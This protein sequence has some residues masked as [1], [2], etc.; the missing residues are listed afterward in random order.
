MLLVRHDSLL[1]A[2]VGCAG[3]RGQDRPAHPADL[4]ESSWSP[5][6]RRIAFDSNRAGGPA[7]LYV[8]DA[9]GAN[10][11]NLTNHG[12]FD[13]WPAWSPDGRRIVFGSNRSG[14]FRIWV[15]NADGSEAQLLADVPGRCTSPKWSPD[16]RWI[17]FD[18]ALE[19]SCEI[20]RVPAPT[21]QGL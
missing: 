8:M 3:A 2:A 1:A 5:D 17:S 6:S 15:M 4:R 16:G 19:R 10:A 11:R 12:G 13:G 20:L 9:G 21:P 7:K 18:R 14:E